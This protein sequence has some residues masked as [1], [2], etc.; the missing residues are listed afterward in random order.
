MSTIFARRTLG[1]LFLLV[2]TATPVWSQTT[3]PGFNKSGGY[4]GVTFMP[5]F[6]FDGVTFDGESIYEEIGGNDITILPR[7]NSQPLVRVALGYRGKQ[8]GLEVSYERTH[9]DGVFLGATGTAV[10]QAVNIDGRYFFLTGSRIQP[11]IGAGGTMP[12]F[13]V[14]DGSFL[15][16]E[17]ADA[18]FKGYGVNAEAGVTVYPHRQFGVSVGYNYRVLSF[19]QVTGVHDKLFDL[20]PRFRE[21]TKSIVVSTHVIF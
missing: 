2:I 15:D 5:A 10:F 4:A 9:H 3:S 6:E 19:D 16:D 18:K 21:N 7:F 14:K 8:A 12:F 13:N 17:V 11:Y 1:V 20:K